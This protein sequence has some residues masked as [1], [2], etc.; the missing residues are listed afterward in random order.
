[1]VDSLLRLF[2]DHPQLAIIISIVVSIGVALSGVLPSFF[3]TAANIMFFGFWNGAIISF[4]GEAVGAGITFILYRRGFKKGVEK[5][6]DQYPKLKRL[7]NAE[8]TDAFFGVFSL[9]LIPF[10]PSG[11]ITFAAAVGKITFTVFI[12]ASSLGK[13]PALLMEAYA[14]YEVT[15]F[16]WPGKIILVIIAGALL[17][18]LIKKKKTSP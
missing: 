18:W 4:L 7:V 5:R 12:I 1:M 3:I 16:N 2:N 6:L 10:V 13:I 14:V 8:G 15:A 17:Y 11:L 9:R